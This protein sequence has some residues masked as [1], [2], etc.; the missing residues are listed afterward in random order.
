MKTIAVIGAMPSELADIREYFKRTL[1]LELELFSHVSGSV[2]FIVSIAMQNDKLT[3]MGI[4][5]M[6]DYEE[7]TQPWKKYKRMIK[8]IISS[9]FSIS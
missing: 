6:E 3:I 2:N 4:G 9:F 1:N 8:E 7:E 5:E